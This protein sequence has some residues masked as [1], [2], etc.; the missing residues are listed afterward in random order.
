MLSTKQ[1]FR[2]IALVF[3]A[4]F[5]VMYLF[6]ILYGYSYK[7]FQGNDTGGNSFLSGIEKQRK[8]YASEKI[9]SYMPSDAGTASI[10]GD[11][12]YEKVAN[13]RS[14]SSNFTAD[15]K[16]I[17]GTIKRFEAIVSTAGIR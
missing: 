17:H 9:K 4:V 14:K 15:E 2:R 13:V 12:K 1:Q 6:R 8:N 10:A 16:L 7:G 3:I 11:Q 5:I